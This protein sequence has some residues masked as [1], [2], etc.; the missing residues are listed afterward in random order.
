M[1]CIEFKNWILDIDAHDRTSEQEAKL[2]MAACPQCK[3]LYSLDQT[4]EAQFSKSLAEVD[5]PANLYSRIKRDIPST[6]AKKNRL[7]VKWKMGVPALAAAAI[8]YLVL[9]NLPWQQ[10][11]N[12]DH[13]GSLALE[14]HL[15]DRQGMAFKS[16]EI[17]DVAT[18]FLSR[19]GF[20]AAPPDLVHRGY[21]FRGGRQCKL[22]SKDAAYL[23]YEK[24]GKKCSLFIM[25]PDDLKFTLEKD[26]KYYVNVK[27]HDIEVW[28]ADGLIY[29]MVV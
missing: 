29:A 21:V 16:D 9:L 20:A 3:K 15:N 23:F 7:A 2:H 22:G 11:K 13:I 8:V 4:I 17:V 19:I 6:E 24:N 26:K 25:N 12:V 28:T 18:W 14:N 5:P 10:I 27:D 1:N